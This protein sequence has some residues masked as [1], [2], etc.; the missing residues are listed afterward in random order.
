MFRKAQFHG[1][2]LPRSGR[3]RG[4]SGQ[5][6]RSDTRAV[7]DIG[8]NSIKLRVVRRRKNVLRTLADTTEVVRLGRGLERGY[9]E[10]ETMRHGVGVVWRLARLAGEMGARPR[11]VGTMALRVAKNAPDFVSRVR[12]RTGVTIEILSGEEEARLAWRG[13]THDLRAGMGDVAVFDTGGGSTEFVFGSEARIAK[14]VS[15]A[16]GAVRLTEKFFDADPVAPDSVARA[17]AYIREMFHAEKMFSEK[18]SP[19]SVIGLG[20]GVAAM[21]SVK[22]GLTLFNPMKLGGTLLTR[23]DIESQV[24]LYASLP[25]AGRM[26][27]P[28]LPVRRADIVLASACIVRCAL[29]A[30][31]VDFFRASINGLRH[32]LI[33]E[34]FESRR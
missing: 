5:R 7:I 1:H 26:K 27:I 24:K 11:L 15:V 23:D 34:M 13:A 28:G 30:L 19:L 29:D 14:S 32:G 17:S 2:G 4:I 33:I 22:L 3:F 9:I 31:G 12:E 10:E 21:A 18:P 8:S 6:V 25:L 20:G 16:A